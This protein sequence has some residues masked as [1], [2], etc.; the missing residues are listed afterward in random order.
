MQIEGPQ[1]ESWHGAPYSFGQRILF[2]AK[3]SLEA[4]EPKESM[5][6]IPRLWHRDS[7]KLPKNSSF[8]LFLVE[9]VEPMAL[10]IGQVLYD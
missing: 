5:S 3:C 7:G 8:P 1:L 6:D 2:P 10:N 4:K 9:D